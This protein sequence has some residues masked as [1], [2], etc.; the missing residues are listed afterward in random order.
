VIYR[1]DEDGDRAIFESFS[2]N[3]GAAYAAR[4]EQF[5]QGEFV[6]RARSASFEIRLLVDDVGRALSVCAFEPHTEPDSWYV[7]VLAVT[8]AHRGNGYGALLLDQL[9]DELGE[10]T[11]ARYAVWQVEQDNE[12]AHRLSRNAGAKPDPYHRSAR[13]ITYYVDL[14]L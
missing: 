5:I 6:E 4:V 14:A 3:P 12:A 7:V 9:L 10:R 8:L 11:P 2:C 1:P 13:H